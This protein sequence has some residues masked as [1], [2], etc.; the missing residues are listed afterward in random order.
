MLPGQLIVLAQG[1]VASAPESGRRLR[2]AKS[3]GSNRS[4]P[5][6]P[7]GEVAP[8]LHTP[9]KQVTSTPASEERAK[10]RFVHEHERPLAS[11]FPEREPSDLPKPIRV[12]R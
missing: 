10:A 6:F 11:D 4:L 7:A 1:R 2:E 3:E 8:P 9:T 5:D 12:G